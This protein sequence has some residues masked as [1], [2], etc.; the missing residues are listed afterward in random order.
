MGDYITVASVRRTCGI[1]STEISDDDVE[2]TIVECE[3]QIPKFLN[4]AFTPTERIDILDGNGTTRLMLNKNPILAV[5]ALEIDGDTEDPGYVRIYRESGKIELNTDEDL[6]NSTFKVGSQK[7]VVKYI[8]GWLGNSSTTTTSSAATEAGT[9]VS[10]TVASITGFADNN[11]VEIVGMD[12][13]KE[14][15]QIDGDPAAGTIVVDQ[16]VYSHESGSIVTL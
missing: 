9:S 14:V 8:H 5:R 13:Y 12:G 6:T 10:I 4:T 15:A 7:I 16:L 1:G 3:A 11:W 2:A